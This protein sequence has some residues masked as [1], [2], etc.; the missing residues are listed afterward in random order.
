MV[1]GGLTKNIVGC[2]AVL[3]RE[4]SVKASQDQILEIIQKQA[5][6]TT[7]TITRD[8]KIEDAGIDSFGLVEIIFEVEDL[9]G[10]DV[11]YN[12]NDGT[13]ENAETVGDI[14]DEVLGLLE[15]A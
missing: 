8:T 14:L 3:P 7:A 10:I 12:A 6:D 1:C 4:S 2:H 15:T 9:L 11:P 13:F 5:V